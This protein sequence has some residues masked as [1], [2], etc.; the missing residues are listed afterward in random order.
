MK[1]KPPVL[2]IPAGG[3]GM[4]MT[5][6][7]TIRWMWIL[8]ITLLEQVL[9]H[10]RAVNDNDF[11]RVKTKDDWQSFLIYL[12]EEPEVYRNRLEKLEGRSQT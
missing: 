10:S 3:D 1:S 12:P 4:E 2:P 5:F 9:D 8:I 7:R 11:V 6:M